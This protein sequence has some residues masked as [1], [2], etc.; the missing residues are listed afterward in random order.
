[1]DWPLFVIL[2]IAGLVV[3]RWATTHFRTVPEG[4]VAVTQWMD[5]YRRSVAQPYLLWPFEEEVIQILVRQREVTTEVPAV[6]THGGM[7]VTVVLRYALSIDLAKMHRDELYYSE[8]ERKEQEVKI[9]KNILQ[10]AV[11]QAPRPKPVA[12]GLPTKDQNRVDLEMFFSPFLGDSF[13][14]LR[15]QVQT[16]ARLRLAEHGLIVT[17]DPMVINRLILPPD[18]VQS[19]TELLVHNFDSTMLYDA[20]KRVKAAAPDMSDST[21][22]QLVNVFQNPSADMRS[23]FTNGSLAPE[24]YIQDRDTFLRPQATPNPAAHIQTPPRSAPSPVE[25]SP[26]Q[27]STEAVGNGQP[28]NLPLRREDMAMLKA[29]D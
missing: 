26:T 17:Q 18:L 29:L 15:D 4:Y 2:L 5:R 19:Y 21:L 6:F 27:V 24:M 28:S 16:E 20:I 7:P 8:A 1:M 3:L 23:I 9:L 12:P 11:Q 10:A 22:T 13:F 14:Q 25:H